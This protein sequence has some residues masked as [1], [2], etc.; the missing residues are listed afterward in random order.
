LVPLALAIYSEI[1]GVI[2]SL[3]G[4]E[5]LTTGELWLALFAPI[6][7]VVGAA[8]ALGW[9]CIAYAPI[10]WPQFKAS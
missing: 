7:A 4:G 5:P 2:Y 3:F 1:A 10:K 6:G 8:S 9:W